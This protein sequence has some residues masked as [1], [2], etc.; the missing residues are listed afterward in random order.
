M[1]KR[2]PRNL[3]KSEN[4]HAF[5]TL[6]PALN[7]GCVTGPHP[8]PGR[9]HKTKD[10]RKLCSTVKT[11]SLRLS[12]AV[13]SVIVIQSVIL[14]QS[15]LDSHSSFVSQSIGHF[16]S[17]PFSLSACNFVFKSVKRTRLLGCRPCFFLGQIRTNS[18]ILSGTDCAC[19]T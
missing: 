2:S 13:L 10:H 16:I 7:Q 12:S 3:K 1:L 19:N 15:T 5:S 18:S 8:H 6:D 11:L 4:F 9:D 17:S 14:S